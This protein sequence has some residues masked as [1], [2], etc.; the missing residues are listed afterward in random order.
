MSSAGRT[1]YGVI[2]MKR[3]MV[4]VMAVG[5]V[6]ALSL[7]HSALAKGP[8]GPPA[9]DLIAHLC[10]TVVVVTETENDDG[11]I[12]TTTT[13][14][15]YFKVIEVSTNAWKAHEAHGDSKITDGSYEKG[16]TFETETV[17]VNPPPVVDPPPVEES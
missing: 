2:A 16:D 6:V 3:F 10:D 1:C 12:T 8:K 4:V 17:E 11:T 5:L 14:T 9:K 7:A 15:K 13:T